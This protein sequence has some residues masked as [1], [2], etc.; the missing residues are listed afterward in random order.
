MNDI[1]NDCFF[2]ERQL[3]SC[4][5]RYYIDESELL[6]KLSIMKLLFNRNMILNRNIKGS[7]GKTAILHACSIQN[8]IC[9]E[10][11]EFLFNNNVDINI[12]YSA[13]V[14]DH[15]GDGKY[16]PLM[17]A[18]CNKHVTMDII[19]LLY[20]NNINNEIRLMNDSRFDL[21]T[22][23]LHIAVLYDNYDILQFFIDNIKVT[24]NINQKGYNR[25]TALHLAVQNNNI[26]I[27]KLLLD[28]KNININLIN[29][30]DDTPIKI[31]NYRYESLDIL[32]LLQ[33]FKNKK[34]K[35][36]IWIYN[37]YCNENKY[38]KEKC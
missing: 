36:Y 30:H 15:R 16:S 31:A 4:C 26:K 35:I 29:S 2:F 8:A 12:K 3:H 24:I 9:N 5:D 33:S 19:K 22:N 17:K 37:K 21:A 13:Y 28:H 25:D 7:H 18:I 32:K 1:F 20:S 14:Y 6:H 10:F 34:D 23:A 38:K 27:V 11:I